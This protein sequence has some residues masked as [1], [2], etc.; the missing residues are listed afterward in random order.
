MT[1]QLHRDCAT[2][3][4][5]A[6]RSMLVKADRTVPTICNVPQTSRCYTWSAH[7]LPCQYLQG[8]LFSLR[9]HLNIRH[10]TDIMDP[11][12]AASQLPL[13]L[14]SLAI[15]SPS[16]APLYVRSYTGPDDEL[17]HYHLAHSAVDVIEERSTF[18]LHILTPTTASSRSA[19]RE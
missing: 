4:H 12:T 8:S 2:A 18:A 6:R 10:T 11:R 7:G 13:H 3:C 15:L 5:V 16:N 17:R 14:T 1:L 19:A 9:L